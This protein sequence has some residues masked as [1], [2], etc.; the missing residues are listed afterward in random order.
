MNAAEPVEALPTPNPNPNSNP[1]P[2]PDPYPNPN[3][4]EALLAEMASEVG[5]G[6]VSVY[7]GG[8]MGGA[9][10][11]ANITS[12]SVPTSLALLTA[13]ARRAPTL[14]LRLACV[15]HLNT[16]A[17]DGSPACRGMCVGLRGG[18]VRHASRTL[19]LTVTLT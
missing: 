5:A 1:N 12:T 17:A 16:T 6:A 19:F 15:G 8:G 13:V 3:Q 4:V 2:N 9:G 7:I 11:P 18:E 14:S 10:I